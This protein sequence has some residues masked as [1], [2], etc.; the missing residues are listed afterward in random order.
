MVATTAIQ[1]QYVT[2][3]HGKT[4]YIEA[5]TG[6]PV[7]LLHSSGLQSGADD[8]LLN[9]PA[10]AQ[11]FRVLAPDMLG[12][13]LGDQ[14][15]QEYGF[16]YLTDFIREFQDALDIPSAHLVGASMG[17]WLAGLLSYESPNRVDRVIVT[18]HN[19]VD[20]EP[21]PHFDNFKAPA[22]EDIRQWVLKTSKGSGVVAEAVVRER[23]QKAHE[24]GYVETFAGVMRHMGDMTARRRYDMVRRF[25]Y[26]KAPTLYVW[27]RKDRSFPKAAIAQK[28]TPN[29]RLLEMDCGHFVAMEVPEEFNKAAVEFLSGG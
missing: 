11:R 8:W 5:G 22:D 9:V 28:L 20:P 19:G 23:I 1:F 15:P 14:L 24:P 6:H 21:N 2:L 12:W 18:G 13:G 7:I 16:A 17:G 10:L 4:R 27:G 3:S 26:I 29:S 25:P